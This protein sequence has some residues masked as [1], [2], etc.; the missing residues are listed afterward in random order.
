[1]TRLARIGYKGQR[2][3]SQDDSKVLDL[4]HSARA[5]GVGSPANL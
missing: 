1:M 5:Q 2:K 4:T 3:Q